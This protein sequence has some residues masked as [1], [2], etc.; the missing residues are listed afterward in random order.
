LGSF[1]WDLS[2]GVFCLGS[3]AWGLSLGFVRFES[4]AWDLSLGVFRLGSFAWGL[5][6]GIFQL[7]SFAWDLRAGGTGLL[8]PGKPAGGSQGNLAGARCIH[9]AL[10]RR[11]KSLLGTHS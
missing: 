9:E 10:R 2:L 7:G 8:R 11:V 5:L 6:L 4:S 1:A 3:F